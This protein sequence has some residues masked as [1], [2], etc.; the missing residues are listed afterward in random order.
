V[1]STGKVSSGDKVLLSAP[2]LVDI[3]VIVGVLRYESVGGVEKHA[4]IV[5]NGVRHP[6]GSGGGVWAIVPNRSQIQGWVLGWA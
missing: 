4:P 3:I 2:I 1:C 6:I 5:E